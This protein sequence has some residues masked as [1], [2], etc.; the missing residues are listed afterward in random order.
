[1]GLCKSTIGACLVGPLEH[2]F[3]HSLK[4]RHGDGEAWC[5]VAAGEHAAV[6]LYHGSLSIRRDGNGEVPQQ[7]HG[8]CTGRTSLM[9]VRPRH[10]H[11]QGRSGFGTSGGG[12]SSS[13]HES[14][15]WFWR[16]GQIRTDLSRI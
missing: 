6:T 14:E 11:T 9:V 7:L 8:A 10:P 16:S 5:P 1:M 15:G 2:N 13:K 3:N 4:L 12:F